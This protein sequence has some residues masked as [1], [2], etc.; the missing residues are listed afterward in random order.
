MDALIRAARLAPFRMRLSETRAPAALIPHPAAAPSLREQIEAQ[1]RAE[2]AVQLQEKYEAERVRA[3]VDGLAEAKQIASDDRAADRAELRAQ[4]EAAVAA[5]ERTHAEALER[6]ESSVGEVAFAAVCRFVGHKACSLDFVRGLVEQAC[7]QLRSETT[8]TARLH[9]R[10]V[11]L[12]RSVLEGGALRVQSLGL[13][14]V[15]DDTLPLG[16]CV[17]EASSGQFDG[18]L[19]NQLRRLHGVLTAK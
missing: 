15:A 19:E 17:L 12:L 14:L 1:L 5:L 16:G 2:M 7:A 8:A 10:D 18:G 3:R 4:L 6:L 13:T 11:D 9:P